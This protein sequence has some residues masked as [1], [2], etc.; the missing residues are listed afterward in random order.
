MDKRA[1]RQRLLRQR[2]QL[3]DRSCRVLS[4]KIQQHLVVADCFSSSRTLALYSPINNEVRTDLLFLAARN[5]GKQ[6]CF[7]RVCGER[8][9]FVRVDSVGALESGTFGVCEPVAGD[10]VVADEIDLLV[11]PGVAFDHSGHRLGYGKGFYDRELA[12]CA[13]TVTAVGL[14]YGFQLC[15][16]LPAEEHDQPLDLIATETGLIPCRKK[17]TG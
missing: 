5:A 13:V 3:T 12:A 2:K 8:L 14:G 6:V 7:P 15:Q 10:L 4:Q 9:Q 16:R 1:I 17:A 11:V